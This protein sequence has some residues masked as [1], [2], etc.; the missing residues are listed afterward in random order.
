MSDRQKIALARLKDAGGCASAY[1]LANGTAMT[2]SQM[3]A[4][5]RQ[6]ERK[7]FAIPAS[8]MFRNTIRNHHWYPSAAGL[9]ATP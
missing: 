1:W 6:L 4:T 3:T 8:S 9:E 5:L 7:G 2:T